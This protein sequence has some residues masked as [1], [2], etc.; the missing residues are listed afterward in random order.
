MVTPFGPVVLAC[1]LGGRE[2][3]VPDE[4][5][6]R[7]AGGWVARCRTD[8]ADV[9]VMAAPVAPPLTDHFGPLDG[10]WGVVWSIDAT[11]GIGS[12]SVSAVLRDFPPGVSGGGDCGE[13]LAAV[14]YENL[15]TVLSIGTHDEEAL[16]ARAGV[17][18]GRW[19]GPLPSRWRGL[20]WPQ[21]QSRFAVDVGRRHGVECQLPGLEP[22][23]HVDL[24]VAIAWGPRRDDAATWYAVDTTPEQILSSS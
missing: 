17:E 15:D 4:V 5:T 7:V 23:E 6:D 18:A 8:V 20:L 12:V 1:A 16:D 24:H 2:V 11:I 22:G 10:Y 19:V 13:L 9:R 3:G 14:T 21:R